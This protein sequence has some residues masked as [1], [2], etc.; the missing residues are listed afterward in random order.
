MGVSPEEYMS[1][2]LVVTSSQFASSMQ[3]PCST[4]VS[5]TEAIWTNFTLFYVKVNIGSC[6]GSPS[7]CF[8]DLCPSHQ[9]MMCVRGYLYLEVLNYEVTLVMSPVI[10]ATQRR[11]V[12]NWVWLHLMLTSSCCRKSSMRKWRNLHFQVLGTEL[13]P[14]G[15]HVDFAL[16]PQCGVHPAQKNP[17]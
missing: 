15:L 17:S 2:L 14:S 4:I 6:V 16:C 1:E 11:I 3:M 7:W 9:T 10:Q 12:H 5:F 13:L 8:A